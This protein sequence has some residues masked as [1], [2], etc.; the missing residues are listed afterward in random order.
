MITFTEFATRKKLITDTNIL[1]HI[2]LL[3]NSLTKEN[4]KE[5]SYNLYQFV[6][7]EDPSEDI[8]TGHKFFKTKVIKEPFTRKDLMQKGLQ[9]F[10][11]V[12]ARHAERLRHPG[13]PDFDTEGLV[14]FENFLPDDKVKPI[15]KEIEQFP[16]IENIQPS[17]NITNITKD[18]TPEIYDLLF[19]S[20]LFKICVEAVH[21]KPEDVDA[22]NHFCKTTYIQRLENIPGPNDIQKVCHSDV[23]YPCL[24]YWYFPEDVTLEQGPFNFALNSVELTYE[25]LDFW[26]EE[27]IK[28]VT[29]TWDQRRN[30]GHAE[31]SLRAFPEDL[32][33]MGFELTPVVV[34]ANTLIIGNTSGWHARGD[35]KVR[36]IRNAVHGA[37]RV[38]TPYDTYANK[39]KDEK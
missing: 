9:A 29:D 10:R 16:L 11:M 22:W 1:K 4:F 34:K 25:V 8:F 24:K 17:N 2:E 7:N 23:F 26:H 27:S 30:K 36:S 6:F 3:E 37:I 38:E 32:Q 21:R 33:R 18:I 13:N 5:V 19:N 39:M 35:A 28:I 14:R 12:L 20:N 31:G 15:L